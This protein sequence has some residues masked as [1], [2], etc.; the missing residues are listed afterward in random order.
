VLLYLALFLIR[1]FPP[2]PRAPAPTRPLAPYPR[3]A[4]GVSVHASCADPPPRSQPPRPHR[5]D[6]RPSEAV[7]GAP[8][9]RRRPSFSDI[10]TPSRAQGG[11]GAGAGAGAGGGEN[12]VLDRV[13]SLEA[14]PL[15]KH[16]TLKKTQTLPAHFYWLNPLPISVES[17]HGTARRL[18]AA[19]RPAPTRGATGRF[20]SSGASSRSSVPRPGRGPARAA[21]SRP[22]RSTP[23]RI[24]TADSPRERPPPPPLVLSGHAASITPY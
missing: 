2:R 23:F 9:G 18:G 1:H 6:H 20:S 17:C 5:L 19:P 10:D 11:K 22:L 24:R 7:S 15:R 16:S 3:V 13:L 21:N 8:R 12:G 14:P 4:Y